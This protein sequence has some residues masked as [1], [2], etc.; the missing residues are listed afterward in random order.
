M[1][2]RELVVG[3]QIRV[4]VSRSLAQRTLDLRPRRHRIRANVPHRHNKLVVR[5]SSGERTLAFNHDHMNIPF[6]QG[7]AIEQIG[8][9]VEGSDLR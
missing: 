9:E 7:I 5:Q 1:R 4:V 6:A 8:R 2:K 3:D